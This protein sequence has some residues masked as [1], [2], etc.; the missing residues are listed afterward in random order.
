MGRIFPVLF[1]ILIGPAAGCSVNPCQQLAER[2]CN[3]IRNEAVA[4]GEGASIILTVSIGV[5][6]LPERFATDPQAGAKYLLE[7]ADEAVYRAKQAGRDQV[8]EAT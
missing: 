3:G 8:V 5:S 2:I 7:T 4:I 1:A 6:S